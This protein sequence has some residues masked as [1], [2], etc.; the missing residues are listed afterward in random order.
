MKNNITLHRLIDNSKETGTDK[1]RYHSYLNFYETIFSPI[2]EKVNNILEIGVLRGGSLK[3]WNDYFINASIYGVDNAAA[4]RYKPMGL[5]KRPRVHLI[6]SD[7]YSE[8][9]IKKEFIR[10][11]LKFDIIIDD[12]PHTLESQEFVIK[13]YLKI[14]SNN[15]ILIIED[16]RSIDNALR[17]KQQIP[18]NLQPHSYIKDLRKRKGVWDD[19]LLVIH[20]N[21]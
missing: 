17:L 19:I 10:N 18:P 13:N 12:G 21:G 2:K 7:A 8:K 16:V 9:F 11:N 1:N 14:L 20:K 5:D 3:L 4:V 6:E 15:G